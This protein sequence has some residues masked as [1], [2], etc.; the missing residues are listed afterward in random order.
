MISH[1]DKTAQMHLWSIN[2]REF[3]S[4]SR[5]MDEIANRGGYT[6]KNGTENKHTQLK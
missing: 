3:H 1:I 5:S 2:W 6:E 4:S